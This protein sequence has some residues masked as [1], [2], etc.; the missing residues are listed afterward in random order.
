MAEPNSSAIATGTVS[1]S[2]AVLGME[3]IHL[4]FGLFGGMV[5][6][7]ATGI[8]G[9]ARVAT[10]LATAT[11]FA[12]V[13]S[14]LAVAW[15][16]DSFGFLTKVNPAHLSNFAAMLV[17]FGSQWLLRTAIAKMGGRLG[18]PGDPPPAGK[19]QGGG[20]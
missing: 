20:A 8:V 15:L 1:L 10:T 5:A 19:A 6:V 12:G 7:L 18:G 3:S 13:G 11:L 4:L 14:P 9:R 17:G 2:G 16:L